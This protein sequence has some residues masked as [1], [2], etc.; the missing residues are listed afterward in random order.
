MIK[1]WQHKGLKDF[2]E[3]GSLA[4]IQPSH[5]KKL[6]QRLNVINRAREIQE[7]NLP[8]YR[9][10]RLKGDRSDIWAIDATGNWRLTFKF[11]Q[12]DAYILD[13]EDYH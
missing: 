6:R 13:Y 4:G 5:E 7:I 1:T 3:T 12:G 8:A 10:H 2:F 9:L 11:E